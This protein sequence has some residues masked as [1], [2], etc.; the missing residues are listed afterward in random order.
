MGFLVGYVWDTSTLVVNTDQKRLFVV[1]HHLPEPVLH[2]IC[3]NTQYL[4]ISYLE[5]MTQCTLHSVCYKQ[6]TYME[7]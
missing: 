5:A 1:D 7:G 6:K 4:R 2:Y 3:M